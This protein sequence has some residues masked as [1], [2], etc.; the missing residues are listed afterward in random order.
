MNK[1]NIKN[2]SFLLFSLL[3][4]SDLIYAITLPK[5]S[6]GQWLLSGDLGAVWPNI[7]KTITVDNGSGFPVPGNIDQYSAYSSHEEGMLAAT[8]G[9]RWTQQA[10]PLFPA[11]ELALRYQ[12]LFPQ[13]ITGT[14]TQFSLGM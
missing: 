9:Y 12:Y 10:Q 5:Y 11:V 13:N 14:V 8:A 6:Q 4:A 3:S 1:M 7:S 2:A